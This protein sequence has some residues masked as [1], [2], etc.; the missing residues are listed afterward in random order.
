M[1]P[2]QFLNIK[3]Q[4]QSQIAALQ[5]EIEDAWTESNK[6]PPPEQLRPATA[7][8]IVIGAVIW[9]HRGPDELFPTEWGW[10]EVEE[11]RDP[12][13]EWK[14]FI[15]DGCRYGLYGAFVES[16]TTPA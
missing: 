1:T 14:A 4:K 15:S 10:L 13:D 7:E 12:G 3:R 9:Y 6:T 16:T 5:V 8:D 11:V 2:T